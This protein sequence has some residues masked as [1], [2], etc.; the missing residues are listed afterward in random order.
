[1]SLPESVK[2]FWND[3]KVETWTPKQAFAANRWGE[4]SY[5]E[6]VIRIDGGASDPQQAETLIHELLHGIFHTMLPDLDGDQSEN[7]VLK[8]S[9]GL[10]TLIRD[11]PD[12]FDWI[13]EALSDG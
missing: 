11:N 4:I 10:A 8:M 1:M 12:V 7:M 2:I 3:Y 13:V 9:A 5:N 6:S